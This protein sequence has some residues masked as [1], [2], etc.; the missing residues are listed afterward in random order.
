MRVF[1]H[2]DLTSLVSRCRRTSAPSLLGVSLAVALNFI[3]PIHIAKFL[4]RLQG[5]CRTAL[6]HTNVDHRNIQARL[7]YLL[8]VDA[9]IS[10]TLSI[11]ATRVLAIL[12]CSPTITRKGLRNAN[13]MTDSRV[14]PQKNIDTRCYWLIYFPRIRTGLPLRDR[15]LE[16]L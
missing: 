5:L 3:L 14:H 1:I 15:I 10:A 7:R 11:L 8:Q 2:S 12:A 16:S 6:Q 9:V 13:L 4:S